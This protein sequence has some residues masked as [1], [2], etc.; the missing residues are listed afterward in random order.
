MDRADKW[1]IGIML[2]IV[3]IFVALFALAVAYDMDER[4]ACKAAGGYYLS[5][6]GGSECVDPNI[7]IKVK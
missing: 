1:F 6:R 7:I 4:A 2:S 5:F 3:G